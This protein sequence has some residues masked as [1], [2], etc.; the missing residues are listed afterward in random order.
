MRDTELYRHL[1]GVVSPWTVAR[2]NLDIAQ[3]RVDVFV[4]DAA[5]ASWQ[6]PECGASCPL[7]DHDGERCWR[8]MDSC[9]FET[10]LH[11]RV[12]RVDCE[13]HG[14]RQVRVP[15]AEP[16]SR[17]TSLFE[18]LA[19]DVLKETSI[20]GAAGLLGL[21]WD[22][23]HHIQQ[24]AVERGLGRRD[25]E[26]PKYLGIDEKN[27]GKRAGFA[28]VS[29]NLDEGTVIDVAE[30]R[31][32]ASLFRSLGAFCINDLEQVEGVAMDMSPTF[33]AAILDCVPHAQEKIVFDRFHIVQHANHAVDQV[34]RA[35]NKNLLTLNDDQL[36]G[37]R[38]M[39]LYGREN[40][41]S[42]Y[43][44]TFD[45]LR[46]GKL[47]TARAWALKEQLR[48]LWDH[49]TLKR[50]QAW[51]TDWYSWA[52]RSRLEPI[53]KVARMVK[54]HLPN[55]L[56]F[57]THRITNATTEALNGVIKGLSKRAYG[58]RNFVNFRTAVLFACGGLDLYPATC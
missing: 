44:A 28:T 2:V 53:K 30:G 38:Y 25:Q 8:H 35:E 24:R 52:I 39:W 22:E 4:E 16:G 17:F 46:V 58:F 3:K 10:H 47:H 12:P 13:K 36:K 50:G 27:I 45:T 20:E 32:K 26:V 40:L 51:W 15:W 37:T 56:T 11:A 31:T 34:R 42:K 19:I 33:I 14:V 7:H 41:P 57:F 1:L 23:V 55:V 29:T 6:C 43:E 5:G 18:R 54:A 21:S 49:P 9:H 48:D